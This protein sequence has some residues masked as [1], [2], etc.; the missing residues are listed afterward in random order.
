MPAAY[1]EGDNTAAANAPQTANTANMQ[2]IYL[3][4]KDTKTAMRCSFG[5]GAGGANTYDLGI[6]D[7][8]GA[9]STPGNLL[10]SR[11]ATSTAAGV[12][13]FTF[14]TALTL[15]PGVYWLAM[16]INNAV[17][18]ILRFPL[19][20]TNLMLAMSGTNATNLPALASSL[21]GL[22]NTNKRMVIVALRQGGWS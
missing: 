19:G 8:S 2:A 11:G 18:T 6:Y 10:V 3:P 7:A 9:N 21:A 13:T 1:R 15:M 14:G 4:S 17:D 12:Q 22:A 16:W 20:T 5:A